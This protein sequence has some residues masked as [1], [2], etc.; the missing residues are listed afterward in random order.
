MWDRVLRTAGIDMS[1]PDSRLVFM[2]SLPTGHA[3]LKQT[4]PKK[5]TS[6]IPK[7]NS[8]HLR[9]VARVENLP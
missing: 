3:E 6:D 7:M 4:R 5:T 2:E 9:L 1:D 8:Q